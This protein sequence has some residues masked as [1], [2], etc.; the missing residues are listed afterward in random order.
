MMS[1]A[2]SLSS[3]DFITLC[4]RLQCSADFFTLITEEAVTTPGL[5]APGQNKSNIPTA[6]AMS[7]HPMNLVGMKNIVFLHFT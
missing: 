2:L 6:S 1:Q 4:L 3:L 5:S 7:S